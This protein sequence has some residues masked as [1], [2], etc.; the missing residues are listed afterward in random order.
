MRDVIEAYEMRFG[1]EA[2]LTDM[3][4]GLVRVSDRHRRVDPIQRASWIKLV[5][6]AA[7]ALLGARNALR[8][9]EEERERGKK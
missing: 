9:L 1:L 3:A 5:N 4:D 6:A 7:I 2:L 8:R